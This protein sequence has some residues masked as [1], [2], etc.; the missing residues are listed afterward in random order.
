[1]VNLK[2]G[3]NTGGRSKYDALNRRVQ[4]YSVYYPPGQSCQTETKN[5]FYNLESVVSETD[6]N[7][8]VI[9]EYVYG[10]GIDEILLQYSGSEKFYYHQN[11]LG[12][13]IAISDKNGNVVRQFKYDPYGQIK[14]YDENDIFIEDAFQWQNYFLFTGREYDPETGLYYY[15]ARYY[16][17]NIGRFMSRD[18]L[19][20]ADGLNLYTY[21]QNNPVNLKDPLGK[22]IEERDC[23]IFC[24]DGHCETACCNSGSGRTPRIWTEEA[25]Y[26]EDQSAESLGY[27]EMYAIEHTWPNVSFTETIA[28]FSISW[29]S[30]T[31]GIDFGSNNIFIYINLLELAE[32]YEK[33][34]SKKEK[35]GIEFAKCLDDCI[36]GFG[37]PLEVID[38]ISGAATYQ[39]VVTTAIGWT[40]QRYI[41]PGISSASNTMQKTASNRA[42]SKYMWDTTAR[43]LNNAGQSFGRLGS[44][45]VTIARYG[46]YASLGALALSAT[47]RAKC[48][49]ECSLQ[50]K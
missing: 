42:Q 50:E 41:G 35:K 13:V 12:S 23:F 20:Y 1:V 31:F 27:P 26:W 15:R 45:I 17:P 8:A 14:A 3:T 18:P 11:S 24:I 19:G 38:F 39:W 25:T 28:Y 29:N 30:M 34:K 22:L 10:N 48:L 6:E 46:K 47:P 2:P 16:N 9:S 7:Y 21:V 40:T 49:I 44:G 33:K 32:A 4:K 36:E 5:Y 37:K 43:L